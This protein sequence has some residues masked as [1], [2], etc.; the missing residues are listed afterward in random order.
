MLDAVERGD[1]DVAIGSIT[2]NA[3]RASKVEFTQPYFI[4]SLSIASEPIETSDWEI[5]FN[6]I[7]SWGFVKGI[8]AL[9]L[10]LVVMDHLRSMISIIIF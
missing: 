9:F 8:G 2:I 1:I 4:T 10:L 5:L 7:F 6:G 3:E